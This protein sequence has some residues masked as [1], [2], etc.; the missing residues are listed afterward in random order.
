M[1]L[2]EA[3]NRSQSEHNTYPD[4]IDSSAGLYEIPELNVVGI[5]TWD[6]RKNSAKRKAVLKITT[7]RGISSNATHFYGTLEV[8]GVY[9]ATLDNIEMSRSLTTEQQKDHPFYN[10]KYNLKILRPI[11]KE[12]I[13]LNP[14]R[15]YCYTEGDL[16][17]NFNSI[18]SLIDDTIKI[19][20]LRF[21]G[22]WRFIVQYPR[23]NKEEIQI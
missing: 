14:D 18:K 8:D 21:T 4:I 3:V 22:D 19:F 2:Q 1:T 6:R 9:N 7:F 10:Y 20:K 16:I 13:K 5:P 17:R 12:E 15:T 11:T 23:G